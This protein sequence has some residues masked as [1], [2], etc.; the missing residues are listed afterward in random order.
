MKL[1]FLDILLSLSLL[2]ITNHFENIHI[3]VIYF[4]TEKLR[5]PSTEKHIFK[6]KSM[7]DK[8]KQTG[9]DC[10]SKKEQFFFFPVIKPL[11]K[12]HG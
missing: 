12:K 11:S 10:R 9:A 5:S 3:I 2:P 7:K 8:R 1:T 4:K 6:P